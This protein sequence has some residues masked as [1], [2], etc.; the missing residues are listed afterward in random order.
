[1]GRWTAEYT[2]MRGLGAPDSLP[3]FGPVVSHTIR[4]AVEAA[5][6]AFLGHL[7]LRIELDDTVH[8]YASTEELETDTVRISPEVVDS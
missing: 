3:V 8:T 1:M 7:E 2:L 6:P 5:R 4:A